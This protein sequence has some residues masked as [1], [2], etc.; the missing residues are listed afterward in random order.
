MRTTR[1]TATTTTVKARLGDDDADLSLS[2]GRRHGCSGAQDAG[3]RVSARA[4][5]QPRG[6][7][8]TRRRRVI[9]S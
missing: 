2:A 7:Y 6:R 8:L 9:P 1:S 5:E 4:G 3:R